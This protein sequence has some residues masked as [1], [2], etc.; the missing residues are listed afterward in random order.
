RTGP[1]QG[2]TLIEVLVTI[3]VFALFSTALVAA[4][5]LCLRYWFKVKDPT[6]AEQNARQAVNTMVAEFRE[7]CI[8]PNV[9][10]S[11]PYQLPTA[12]VTNELQFWEPAPGYDATANGFNTTNNANY[13]LVDYKVG[14]DANGN[15]AL[16]RS[17]TPAPGTGAPTE[18]DPVVSTGIAAGGSPVPL[19]LYVVPAPSNF[20]NSDS[21]AGV[22]VNPNLAVVITVTC[23]GASEITQG[24]LNGHTF[25][26]LAETMLQQ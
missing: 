7:A 9:S 8:N 12:T 23:F 16:I 1:R 18:Q 19:T 2:F 5:T 22:A 11:S 4:L 13:E 6:F 14:N 21:A 20:D 15:V 3:G 17:V 10:T 25:S 24:G 26:A